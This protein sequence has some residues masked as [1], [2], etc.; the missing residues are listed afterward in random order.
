MILTPATPPTTA[1][2]FIVAH[3]MHPDWRGATELALTQLTAQVK[4]QG[5]KSAGNTGFLYISD[6]FADYASDILTTI[7]VRTGIATWT[8]CTGIGVFANTAEYLDEPAVCMMV[9]QLDAEGVRVFSGIDALPKKPV[10]IIRYDDD[11]DIRGDADGALQGDR[12]LVHADSKTPMLADVLADLADRMN[13]G[14]VFGGLVSSRNRDAQ[15]ANTTFAAG[16]SGIAF[17]SHIDVRT[18]ITQGCYPIHPQ[19]RDWRVLEHEGAWISAVSHAARGRSALRALLQDLGL[20]DEEGD[21]HAVD[22]EQLKAK[23]ADGV[24]VSVTPPVLDTSKPILSPSDNRVV[25]RGLAGIDPLRGSI[26]VGG[27]ILPGSTLRFCKRDAQ[28][29]KMDLMRV[30]TELR[31][32]FEEASITP[33][34]AL[35]ISC[36]SRGQPLFGASGAELAI[37]QRGLGFSV[38]KP[39]PLVGFAASGE[40][41][42]AQLHG[43]SAVVSVFA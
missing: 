3:A 40:I 26:A 4:A 14:N 33:R 2:P 11:H 10:R 42:N 9:G 32:E 25:M 6:H 36:L 43:F 20:V 18:R 17:A 41:D 34:G 15:F 27:D 31:E 13:V 21:L 29:A 19:G 16:L 35:V 28:A 24:F 22:P 12:C 7:K 38:D 1:P 23:I 8:G 5:R 30:C 37:I 39:L